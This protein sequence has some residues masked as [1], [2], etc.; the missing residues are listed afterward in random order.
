VR[1]ETFSTP[2][3]IRL[4][5][6]VPAGEVVVVAGETAE[7]SVE[8]EPLGGQE[9]RTAVEEARLELHDGVLVVDVP[10]QRVLRFLMR[11]PEVRL[12]VRCPHGCDLEV[13]VASADVRAS[14]RFA[15]AEIESASGDVS[16]GEV[17]GNANV[18]SASGDLELGRIGGAL[19]AQAASGDIEVE[20]VAGEAKARSASGDVSIALADASLTVQTASGDQRIGSVSSGQVSLRSASGDLWVGI[21]RGS[22]VWVDASSM[23]GDTTS[24][25]DVGAAAPP[26][27]GDEG[28]LVELRAQS[29]SGDI[30]VARAAAGAELER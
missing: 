10:D 8:L 20:H 16:L 21:R 18:K 7:T 29:M 9:S 2:E 25:L 19:S 6:R 27:E 17:D 5:L 11:G 12:T 15:S 14:G 24:E 23:S 4:D 1:R 3:P 22:A 28:P 30:H 26:A 13:G